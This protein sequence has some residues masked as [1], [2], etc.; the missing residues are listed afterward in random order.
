MACGYFKGRGELHFCGTGGGNEPQEDD[1]QHLSQK[2]VT[3]WNFTLGFLVDASPNGTVVSF[4]CPL[5]CSPS[6]EIPYCK[7]KMYLID[8]QVCLEQLGQKLVWMNFSASVYIS[9]LWLLS[10]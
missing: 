7:A 3:L 8:S 4:S 5:F 9:N 10:F 6:K 2:S 1:M